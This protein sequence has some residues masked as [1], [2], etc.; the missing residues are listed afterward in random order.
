VDVHLDALWAAGRVARELAVSPDF[1]CC[2]AA[3]LP[4][5]PG[6]VD[7]VFSY[8]VLQHLDKETVRDVLTGI[9]R[10]LRPGGTCFVQ[11]PNAF[12]M[13]SL[14]RQARR[15]FREAEADTF[16]M[17]YWTRAAIMRAFHEAGFGSVRF[18]AEGFLLQNTQREDIDLLSRAGRPLSE[19]PVGYAGG[20]I[21]I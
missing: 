2:D 21:T 13:V 7:F 14:W 18:R 1:A 17:R 12:G 3:Q 8:S 6:S 10:V 19:E 5:K 11:M 9:A 20:G 4:F 16:E 15:G